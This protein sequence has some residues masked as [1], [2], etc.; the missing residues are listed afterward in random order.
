MI[1][2]R[3][4]IAYDGTAF[5]G[6]ALQPGARTVAGVLT[7][8]LDLLHYERGDIVVA[9]RTDAGVHAT[10]QVVS[11]LRRGGPPTAALS[12]ALND[13]LP[14]DMVVYSAEDVPSE[15]SAR[16]SVRSRSYTYDVRL[17]PLRNPLQ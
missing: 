10:G 17:D 1:N 11:V 14:E 15:C 3:L 13:S 8:A 7:R 5:T 12:R 9:G 6:W 2:T 16:F 4:Q